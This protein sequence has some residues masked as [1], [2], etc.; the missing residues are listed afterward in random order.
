[1]KRGGFHFQVQPARLFSG[2]LGKVVV[3]CSHG[4]NLTLDER[5]L[6]F[7]GS[8]SGWAGIA[9]P[10]TARS[11]ATGTTTD[12]GC[13]ATDRRRVRRRKLHQ[14]PDLARHVITR[15][16]QAWSPEQIAGRLRREAGGEGRISHETI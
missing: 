2:L 1:M 11:A 10:S 12:P 5:K 4:P 14:N 13:A 9:R 8:P 15:L 16:Q 3:A 6:I 7:R